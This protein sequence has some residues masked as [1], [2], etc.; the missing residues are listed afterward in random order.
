MNL[1]KDIN[2]NRPAVHVEM[3]IDINALPHEVKSIYC[4]FDNW[5]WLFPKTIRSARLINEEPGKQIVEVDHKQA[6]KVI[7]ILNYVSPNEVKLEEFKN[8]YDA[9]FLNRF[10]PALN[11]TRYTIIADVFLKGIYKV[12]R[13]FVEGIVRSR[14][15]NYVLIPIKK[16]AEKW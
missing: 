4:D 10:E 16:F 6:G 9:V 8:V 3:F 12:A 11:A 13:P 2:P 15:K 14:I 1:Q 5:G 7:N